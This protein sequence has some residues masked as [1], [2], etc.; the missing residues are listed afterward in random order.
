MEDWTAESKSDLRREG[1]ASR[2]RS[3]AQVQKAFILVEGSDTH[4]HTADAPGSGGSVRVRGKHCIAL[5]SS[6]YSSVKSLAWARQRLGVV[7]WHLWHSHG[8]SIAG[9]W[10]VTEW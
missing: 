10:E 1:E 9:N 3:V 4:T 2:A 5:H 6:G 8:S 7:E